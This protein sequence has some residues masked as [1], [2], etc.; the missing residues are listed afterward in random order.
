MSVFYLP[1]PDMAEVFDHPHVVPSH[2]EGPIAMLFLERVLTCDESA[3][4]P[5]QSSDCLHG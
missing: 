3:D 4:G 2:V 5:K 1:R